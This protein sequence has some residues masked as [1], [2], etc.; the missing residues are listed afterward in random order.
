MARPRSTGSPP[1]LDLAPEEQ[2]RRAVARADERPARDVAEPE[3]EPGLPPGREPLRRHPLDDRQ[4]PRARAQVLPE[5][6][7]LDARRAE[8]PHRLDDLA[9][10]LAEPHHDRRLRHDAREL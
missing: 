4:V 5:R 7:D 3:S 2:L 1:R 6:E 8:V 10:R 9:V